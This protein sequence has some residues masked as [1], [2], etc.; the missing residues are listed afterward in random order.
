MRLRSCVSLG[1]L[2]F[3]VSP[4][5]ELRRLMKVEVVGLD[6]SLTSTG[7]AFGEDF[8]QAI[9][10]AHKGPKRLAVMRDL[11][12]TAVSTVSAPY[13]VIEG[14]SFGSRNSQAH[15]IGELG[16][17][18][19]VALWERAIP[20][21]EIAPTARAKFAT[22]RGNASKNEVVSAIS[23]RTGVVWSGKGGDDRC[24]A[25][26]LQEMGLAHFGQARFDWPV[27]NMMSLDKVDWS[28]FS[29]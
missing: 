28:S 17:V 19:R 20:Y 12:M 21:V 26:I 18:I 2:G 3:L 25:W 7:V 10:T 4:L 8:T 13:V 23:A 24:D 22:G 1:L 5:G 11:V 9:S 6:L 15:S 14:Y 29:K 16:G 27:L